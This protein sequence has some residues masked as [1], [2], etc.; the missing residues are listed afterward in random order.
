MTQASPAGDCCTLEHLVF[1]C[2]G[3]IVFRPAEADGTPAMIFSLGGSLAAVPLRSLQREFGIGPDSADGQML[4]YIVLAL[5]FV[6]EVRPGDPLPPEVLNGGA[7]W[8]PSPQHQRVA[9]GRLRLQLITAFDDAPGPAWAEAEQAT[10][11]AAAAGL[12]VEARLARALD[13]AAPLLHM[14]AAGVPRLVAAAAEELAFIEALRDRLLRRVG[15]LLVRLNA[16]A[17]CMGHNPGAV[18]LLSRVRRLAGIAHGRMQARFAKAGE[19][20]AQVIEL[21]QDLDAR[22]E[23]VRQHRD[24]LYCSL[25]AW[26]SILV[27]WESSAGGWSQDTWTLLRRTYRFLAPRFMP[28]QEW[29]RVARAH[30]AEEAAQ[31]PMIW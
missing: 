23:A 25:R 17:A 31:A 14:P 8:H 30:R 26:E 16:L 15:V 12:G 5:G 19:C 3:E 28:V 7:S 2:F 22:R 18:E 20:S 6:T 29:Q 9:E 11:L 21:L 1:R 4:G 27:G 24:W 10:V 13:A